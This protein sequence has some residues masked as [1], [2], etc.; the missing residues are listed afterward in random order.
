[1]CMSYQICNTNPT[2]AHFMK[3]K[4]V[5]NYHNYKKYYLDMSAKLYCYVI[6]TLYHASH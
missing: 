1:M 6:E 4:H 5:L 2:S 3:S